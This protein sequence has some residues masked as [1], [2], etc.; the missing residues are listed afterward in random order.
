MDIIELIINEP[1]SFKSYHLIKT[2]KDFVSKWYSILDNTDFSVSGE[3]NLLNKLVSTSK[4]VKCS[5]EIPDIPIFL[6]I[7]DSFLYKQEPKGSDIFIETKYATK[8]NLR[9]NM[10]K[11]FIIF[12]NNKE[13]NFLDYDNDNNPILGKL[14]SRI[15]EWDRKTFADW[16]LDKGLIYEK[17][18]TL[19][20]IQKIDII[21]YIK[22]QWNTIWSKDLEQDLNEHFIYSGFSDRH[23]IFTTFQCLFKGLE[24]E[25]LPKEFFDEKLQSIMNTLNKFSSYSKEV[26]NTINTYNYIKMDTKVPNVHKVKKIIKKI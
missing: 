11:N 25:N 18:N 20:V 12:L 4:E 9:K 23:T 8:E 24:Q 10:F 26:S 15:I 13:V 16:M 21:Q 17:F 1:E 3:N 14:I 2:K 19:E 5:K 6:P 22:N 7:L